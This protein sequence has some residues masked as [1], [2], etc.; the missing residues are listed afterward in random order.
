MLPRNVIADDDRGVVT[1]GDHEVT[2]FIDDVGCIKCDRP[3]IYYDRYDAYFCAECNLWLE[4][5]CADPGC[6]YCR[7]R[8]A[9]P[10][11]EKG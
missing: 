6:D 9:S 8:P 4:G 2:G 11:G 7:N 5:A 3:R 1:I 10:L